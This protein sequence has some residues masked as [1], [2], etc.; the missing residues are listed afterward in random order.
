VPA[1]NRRRRGTRFPSVQGLDG[2]AQAQ[3][4]GFGRRIGRGGTI[5][6]HAAATSG[7]G[8]HG[9]PEVIFCLD[10]FEPLNIQPHPGRQWTD[11]GGKHNRGPHRRW[12]RIE[13]QFTALPP[14]VVSQ[15]GA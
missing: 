5:G 2:H 6:R 4:S 15:R 7:G 3:Q 11:R 8:E 14:W 1:P 10:E 13:A 9:E 12:P